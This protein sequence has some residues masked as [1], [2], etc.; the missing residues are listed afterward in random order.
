M[1]WTRNKLVRTSVSTWALVG[2]AWS[3]WSCRCGWVRTT[4]TWGWRCWLCWD[5]TCPAGIWAL[6]NFYT[7]LTQLDL[8]LNTTS[9]GMR[10]KFPTRA[11]LFPQKS[12][13][14]PLDWSQQFGIFHFDKFCLSSF[15]FID[16]RSRWE[17]VCLFS[18][19]GTR[20]CI[21]RRKIV[22]GKF[23]DFCAEKCVYN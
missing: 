23:F 2:M 14:V 5:T 6:C 17:G 1:A 20:T 13:N 10:L 19:H 16:L 9:G 4:V 18:S 11:R 8:R 12:K 3:S 15:L 22:H 21:K 7:D